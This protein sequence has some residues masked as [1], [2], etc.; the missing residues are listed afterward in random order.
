MVI[1]LIKAI[2]KDTTAQMKIQIEWI[3]AFQMKNGM[4]R[5]DRLATILF[6]LSLEYIIQKVPIA[7]NSTVFYKSAQIVGYADDINILG[8]SRAVVEEV[9][10]AV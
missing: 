9:Y 2:M 7:T 6:N 1:R 4:K 3:N 5:R 8:R 10:S